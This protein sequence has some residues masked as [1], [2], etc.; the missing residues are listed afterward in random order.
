M[1]NTLLLAP[2]CTEGISS[3]M[4]GNKE[5]EFKTWKR[6]LYINIRGK[7]FR[8]KHVVFKEKDLKYIFV[9]RSSKDCVQHRR[10]CSI[11]CVRIYSSFITLC[12]WKTVKKNFMAKHFALCFFCLPTQ[13]QSSN[14]AKENI[15]YLKELELANSKSKNDIDLLIGS[16]F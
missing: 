9:N 5:C 3:S 1:K 11:F 13:K 16:E 6:F 2:I 12:I 14:Y 10:G 4:F 7:P 15:G 8:N